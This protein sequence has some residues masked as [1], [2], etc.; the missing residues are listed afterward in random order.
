MHFCSIQEVVHVSCARDNVTEGMTINLTL[1][2]KGYCLIVSEDHLSKSSSSATGKLPVLEENGNTT[3]LPPVFQNGMTQLTMKSMPV[4]PISSPTPRPGMLRRA[5]SVVTFASAQLSVRDV[6]GILVG[7]TPNDRRCSTSDV[8]TLPAVNIDGC[9]SG[10]KSAQVCPNSVKA[11]TTLQM[12]EEMTTGY[13]R[14]K[15]DL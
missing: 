9:M 6:P 12:T 15:S 4:T 7:R 2:I 3:T 14:L 8:P 10:K 5:K 11:I 13:T 1:L